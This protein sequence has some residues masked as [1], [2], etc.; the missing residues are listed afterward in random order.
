MVDGVAQHVENPTSPVL[1]WASRASASLA[2]R[3]QGSMDGPTQQVLAVQKD[4]AAL[5]QRF[6]MSQGGL[7]VDE[8]AL[9]VSGCAAKLAENL[10]ELEKC[11]IGAIHVGRLEFLK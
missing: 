7:G 3:L 11:C 4:C 5:I 10:A 6:T 1:D 2:T 9:K 8:L